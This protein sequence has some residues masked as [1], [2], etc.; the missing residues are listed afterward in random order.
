M[1][2]FISPPETPALSL[3]VSHS[4]STSDCITAIS[5]ECLN[6]STS[7]FGP[8]L[9][10]LHRLTTLSSTTSTTNIYLHYRRCFFFFHQICRLFRLH[11][12]SGSALRLLSD[13]SLQSGNH[14]SIELRIFFAT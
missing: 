12:V 7:L 1:L 3:S 4:L 2:V 11:R 5:N 6:C 10:L 14:R 13:R 8:P 9:L